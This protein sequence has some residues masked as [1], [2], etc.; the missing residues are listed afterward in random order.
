MQLSKDTSRQCVFA[1]TGGNLAGISNIF[2]D[3]INQT[4]GYSTPAWLDDLIVVNRRSNQDHEKE[5]FDILNKLEKAG[6]RASKKLF[7]C[8]TKGLGHEIDKNE[9]KPKEEKVEAILKLDPPKNPKE[10]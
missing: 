2:H 5:R 10:I 8:Q 1:I 4:L 9:M 6:N 3:N 7:M